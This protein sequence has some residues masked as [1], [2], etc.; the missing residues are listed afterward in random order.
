HGASITTNAPTTTSSGNLSLIQ[1]AGT[2][3]S[4][5]GNLTANGGSIV[6]NNQNANGSIVFGNGTDSIT[7]STNVT[8]AT[9]GTNGQIQIF[10]GTT[11]PPAENGHTS[12]NP[13]NITIQQTTSGTA[14]FG[15]T[16]S[17]V[18]GGGTGANVNLIK[19]NVFFNAPNAT[20]TILLNQG[21][22]ITA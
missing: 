14:F 17:Q 1:T 13:N 18:T 21:T 5:D 11:T 15:H 12:G 3:L 20:G 10:L 7:V 6:I 19:Q 22:T 4:V 16:P 9:K 2:T 8:S